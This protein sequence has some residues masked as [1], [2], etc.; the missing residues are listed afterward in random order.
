[1]EIWLYIYIYIK[2]N[3]GLFCMKTR[4]PI[5]ILYPSSAPFKRGVCRFKGCPKGLGRNRI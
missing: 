5:V 1:M 4:L 2:P 3:M